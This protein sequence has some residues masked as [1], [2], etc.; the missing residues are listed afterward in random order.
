MTFKLPGF[1]KSVLALLSVAVVLFFGA[2]A[3]NS[4]VK[5]S[6]AQAQERFFNAG[7]VQGLADSRGSLNGAG[8][9][10]AT[11]V[12][13]VPGVMEGNSLVAQA[14][15]RVQAEPSVQAQIRFRIDA[16][17]QNLLGNGQYIQLGDGPEKLLR[18]DLKLQVAERTAALQ[19]I[20]G[21]QYYWVRR[22]LP[23]AAYKVARVN[24]RSVRN[25]IAKDKATRDND[26]ESA[27]ITTPADDAWLLL[28]GL[29]ALLE[30]LHRDFEFGSARAGEIEYPVGNDGRA[31]RLPVW[32]VSGTWKA[33]RW[34]ELT[35]SAAKKNKHA[36]PMS[37]PERVDLVLG[38]NERSFS[39]F[40]YRVIY[41]AREAGRA[42]EGKAAELT[43]LVSMEFFNVQ[44]AAELDP[45]DF[46]YNPGEQEIEDL[47][48]VYLQKLGLATKQ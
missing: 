20:S 14:A 48:Q 10:G 11:P 19:Q 30:S 34:K 27:P 23:P 40:P 44:P 24:L 28:G 33:G 26:R 15:R 5:Y 3:I 25:A 36:P 32:A 46:D 31:Q 37:L 18:F 9:G 1:T 39:L 7:A 12:P 38:R 42:G 8:Q 47:T 35:K 22:D 41:Y 43:P 16:A 29:P 17:G 13:S 6:R 21:Q 4:A 2:R 45:R